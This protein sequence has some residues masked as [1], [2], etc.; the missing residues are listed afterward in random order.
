VTNIFAF[1]FKHG[2]FLQYEAAHGNPT[3]GIGFLSEVHP[4]LVWR[5]DAQ[6]ELAA[7]VQSHVTATEKE[8]IANRVKEINAQRGSF[9]QIKAQDN[10][11]SQSTS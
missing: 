11:P 3:S 7:C 1:L 9:P 10:F 2:I 5:E 4:R 8:N 6:H